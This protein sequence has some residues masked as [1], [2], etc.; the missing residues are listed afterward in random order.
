MM[1]GTGLSGLVALG[2]FGAAALGAP[3]A[4][5]DDPPPDPRLVRLQELE[6]KVQADASTKAYDALCQDAQ[7]A[8]ELFKEAEGKSPFRERLLK[9]LNTLAGNK[10]DAVCKAAITAAGDTGD[11]DGAAKILRRFLRP[12]DSPDPSAAL[13]T[14]IEV[15]EKVPDPSLVEPLLNIVTESKN[16]TVAANAMQALGCFKDAKKKREK[17]LEELT[18]T[19]LKDKPGVTPRAYRENQTNPDGASP[20]NQ[21][22]AQNRWVT[23]STV[24][25]TALNK[26]TGQNISTPEEWGEAV[27]SRKG[28][29]GD[30]FRES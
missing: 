2:I 22:G 18:K 4:R 5:A 15:V 12:T 23:L 7:A 20:G 24:L 10:E 3:A 13:V 25:A 27:K 17:I 26:L 28:R 8:A 11:Q 1:R 29:L 14:S 6:T 9:I 16:Y 30:L 21:A 19:V